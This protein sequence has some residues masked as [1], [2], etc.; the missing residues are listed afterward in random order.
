LS[1]AIWGVSAAVFG[2]VMAFAAITLPVARRAVV[3]AAAIAYGL[4]ALGAATFTSSFWI[5]LLAPGALLLTGYWLSGL[6][7]HAPQRWLEI[8]LMKTDRAVGADRWLNRLPRPIVELLEL[9]YAADYVVVGGGAI[10]ASTSGVDAVAYYWALVLTSELASFAPLPWLRSRPPRAVE[11]DEAAAAVHLWAA[12]NKGGGSQ[13]RISYFRRVNVAILNSASV[14]A[15][16]L[17]SGH[18][19]G[20]VAAA[21]GVMPIDSAA[22]WLMMIAAVLIAIAA[23]AGRYHYWIDCVTGGVVAVLVWVLL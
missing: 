15:N 14:Q 1:V 9:S 11:A 23:V 17:P 13:P 12:L 7:F 5:N 21:L 22:G 19:S 10:L 18:V 6:L 20:A 4:L 16:T 3:L 2:L 8:W